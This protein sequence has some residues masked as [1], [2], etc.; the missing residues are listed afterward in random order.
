VNDAIKFRTKLEEFIV[1]FP[2][3]FPESIVNGYQLKETRE[4]LAKPQ[5]APGAI[6]IQ[7]LRG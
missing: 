5:V 6:H 2:D 1:K 4:P 3:L 7:P